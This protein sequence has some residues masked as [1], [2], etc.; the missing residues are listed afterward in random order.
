MSRTRIVATRQRSSASPPLAG[1]PQSHPRGLYLICATVGLERFSFF[2]LTAILVL[3]LNEHFGMS[4]ARAVEVYGYFLCGCYVTP[5]LGGRLC[6]GRM[7]YRRTA[8]L[9]GAVQSIG[10]LLFFAERSI[11]LYGALA[12]MALGGVL[13][14]AGTQA[15]LGSLYAT[16]DPRRDRSFACSTR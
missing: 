5:L 6:D 9:G 13:F 1:T 7:G 4:A 8:L 2:L 14:K 11:I 3:Y 16:G 12:L 10:Y 15:L